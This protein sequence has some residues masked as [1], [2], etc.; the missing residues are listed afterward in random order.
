[1]TFANWKLWV[2][3]G[4]MP[5]IHAI[6][7]AQSHFSPSEEM[8]LVIF[9]RW[10]VAVNESSKEIGQ[11]ILKI[12]P[13]EILEK[14]TTFDLDNFCHTIVLDFIF[15]LPIITKEFYHRLMLHCASNLK[16]RI[17]EDRFTQSS[18]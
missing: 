17:H 14:F 4:S 9:Q 16:H 10:S 7:Y 13:L 1:M 18:P 6:S 12:F 3:N 11:L 5:L 15:E 8:L 2:S